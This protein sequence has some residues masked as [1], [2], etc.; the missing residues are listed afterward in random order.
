MEPFGIV[1]SHSPCSLET[2]PPHGL[3]V[4]IVRLFSL[5]SSV[6]WTYHSLLNCSPIKGQLRCYQ[7]LALTDKAA[8]NIRV[9]VLCEERFSFLWGES[10]RGTITG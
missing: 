8:V 9:Q 4:L 5:L 1:F 6:I 3:W 10:P 2:P 7:F